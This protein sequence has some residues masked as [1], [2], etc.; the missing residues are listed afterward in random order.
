MKKLM[1]IGLT[2]FAA[3]C[4]SLGYAPSAQAYP[5]LSCNVTV[6]AQKVDSGSTLKVHAES[7]QVSTEVP[8]A[9]AADSIQWTADFN[10]VTK[11]SNA[12]VFDTTFK[13]PTV[14]AETVL[15][16]HVKAVHPGASSTCEKSLDITILPGGTVV[17]PPGTLP[18]TGGPRMIFLIAGLGLVAVGGIAIRQSRKAH[19]A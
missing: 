19:A 18:N 2:A 11:T 4:L 7:Q 10:G 5:E 13:V 3:V 15:T 14:T 12:D 16:L 17:S 9:S 8:R 1:V 6:D